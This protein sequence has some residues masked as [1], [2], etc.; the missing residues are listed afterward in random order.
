[1]WL[2]GSWKEAESQ[3]WKKECISGLNNDDSR[4]QEAAR[5]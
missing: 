4:C 3:V 2:L 1:M 5:N